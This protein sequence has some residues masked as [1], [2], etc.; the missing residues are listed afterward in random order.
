MKKP[1]T[2]FILSLLL[3]SCSHL[4]QSS[5]IYQLSPTE[6]VSAAKLEEPFKEIALEICSKEAH[7]I[8]IPD[9]LEIKSLKASSVGLILGELL[10]S[11]YSQECRG[12]I[13]QV[14]FPKHFQLTH[15]GLISLTRNPELIKHQQIAI[16]EA[17]I[18]TY[19][20]T[21]SSLRVFVRQIDV[22]TGVI[23]KMITKEISLPNCPR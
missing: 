3:L 15:E 21:D 20:Y 19:S 1:I 10:R 9:F 16:K 11:H 14:E 4:Y 5:C 6:K 13:I 18:G 7:P 2:L 12:K 17:V 22:E 23:K 8:V